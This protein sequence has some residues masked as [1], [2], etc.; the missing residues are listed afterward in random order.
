MPASE[1]PQGVDWL[2]VC[3]RAAEGVRAAVARFPTTAE[4]AVET[5][6]GAGGDDAL[7]ID[8][9]AE[10]AV[11]AELDALG[12]PLTLISE[13]RGEVALGG[14]GP[15]HVVL[16]PVDG[17][18]NAKRGLP[19]ASVSI[20]LASGPTLADVEFG[21]IA[22]LDPAREWWGTRGE[23]AF[24]DGKP[25][26][27]LEGGPLEVLGL[28]T[29][30]PRLVAEAA[31]ALAGLEARRIR[32]LGSVAVTLA[33]VAEGALDAMLSLRSVRS[34]DVAAGALLVAEAGGAVAFPEAGE[35]PPLA[36]DMRSRVLAARDAELLARL[37]AAFP[38]D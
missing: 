2:E 25:L 17:S 15:L 30:R 9:A 20:A 4:R 14:G 31:P 16:D 37:L 27:P 12:A 35:R 28:E 1:G 33:F 6:R 7:V 5:G 10:D 23:G 26:A 22:A 34:V 8:R 32:A 21:Y 19:F 24:V 36:L 11:V 29:A 18:I 3:R 38:S 13:E